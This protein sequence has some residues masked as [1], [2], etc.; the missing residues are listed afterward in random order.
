[1]NIKTYL[2]FSYLTLFVFAEET[3]TP[4]VTPNGENALCIPINNCK[5]IKQALIFLEQDVIEFARK[6]RCGFEDDGPL[7]C[8]GSVGKPTTPST[9]IDH[10]KKP[11]LRPTDHSLVTP[12]DNVYLP[13]DSLCGI[14]SKGE[15]MIGGE[16]TT[17]DEFPW[18][19]ILV[20]VKND[21]SNSI[22]SFCSATLINH[23]YV[24]TAAECLEIPGYN[25]TEV[26]LGEWRRSTDDD[27][28]DPSDIETCADPVL[29]VPI[30]EKIVHPFYNKKNRNN[31]IALLLL[32]KKIKYSA[33]VRPICL[34]PSDFPQLSQRS[35]VVVSGWST[36]ENGL[37]SD[38]KM[39]TKF[40]VE[41]SNECTSTLPK[42]IREVSGL[43]CSDKNVIYR[44]DTGGPL[45]RIYYMSDDFNNE[46]W[47]LEGIIF[48]LRDF[49]E[50]GAPLIYMKTSKYT[51]WIL[52]NLKHP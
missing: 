34:P 1:M 39:Q 36:S 51:K 20:Y 18:T 42:S 41:E 52:N 23:R 9:V 22:S 5:V 2:L 13:D 40:F 10:T 50:V 19:A 6:S 26:R 17:L 24:L 27:C 43:I 16:F 12:I 15:R 21:Y 31:N 3:E 46:H 49:E 4:C 45:M 7:V 38:V 33:F 25:L 14:Q 28:D 37:L 8:C 48:K 30:I 44:G 47:Y 32:Q 29:D 35:E 11:T